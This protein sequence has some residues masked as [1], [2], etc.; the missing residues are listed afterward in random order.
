MT[1]NLSRLFAMAGLALALSAGA[2]LSQTRWDLP[3]PSLE[4]GFHTRNIAEFIKDVDGRTSGT[5]KITQHPNQSLIRHAD[6]K[7]A[8]RR[9]VVPLGEVLVS[10]QD[11]ESA[12]YGADSIPFLVSGY[13]GALKLY[14]AQKPFLQKLLEREGIILLFSVPFPPQGILTNREIATAADLAGAKL[15]NG[16]ATTERFATLTGAVPTSIPSGEMAEGFK[17][18]KIDAAI[19]S[20]PAAAGMSA[21][22]F[23]THFYDIQAWFP[24]NMVIMNKSHFEGLTDGERRAL[25]EAGAAAETRGWEMS[26]AET[27][28]KTELLAKSGVKV[29]APADALRQ[30]FGDIGRRMTEDWLR[31]AGP[32][33]KAL[34][35][36]F[37]KR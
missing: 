10:R 12:I 26:R 9:G 11:E 27:R 33:G 15:R 5:L 16:G 36:A 35:D 3:T 23:A 8:V 17:S 7:D 6:I 2:A 24:R 19:L 21:A 34:L 29:V 20:A 28:E 14:Q 4:A 22:K 31:R 32:D 37:A 13:D 1:R 25:L 18:G 30:S